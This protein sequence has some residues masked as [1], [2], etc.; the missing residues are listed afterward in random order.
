VGQRI[1]E[2][3][4][5][6]NEP[7]EEEAQGGQGPELRGHGQGKPA[8]ALARLKVKAIAGHDVAR[9]L[10]EIRDALRTQPDDQIAQRA[11]VRRT[12]RGCQAR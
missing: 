4:A 3:H 10:G 2:E 9:D 12:R 7:G 5:G 11:A 6:P 1:H 8:L